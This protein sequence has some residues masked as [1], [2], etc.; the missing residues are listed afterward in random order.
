MSKNI[1]YNGNSFVKKAG[2]EHSFTKDQLEEY[3]RCSEDIVYFVKNYCKII[4]LDHGLQYF[5]PF[6]YQEKM[7]KVFSQERF[8][9]NL[10]PRQMGKSTV[11]A[12]YL[13]H[14]AIFTPDKSVG[15]LANKA[16]TSREILS[17]IQRMYE[18]LPLWLQP[19]V[20]EW[21]KG[22]MV[23]GNGSWLMAAATSSDSIRGFSFNVIY[24]D[25]FAHVDQQVEFWES[26]YPV[27]SSGNTSKVLITST[28]NGLDLFYKIYTEAEDGKNNFYPIKVNW[29]EHPA[30][31]DEWKRI[32]LS[33]IGLE[34]FKQEYEN[35]FLGSSGTLI[36][37]EKLA[38]LVIKE[39]I[40]EKD[41]IKQY[42]RPEEGHIYVCI[43]DVS[44]GKG[45]D[46]SAFQIMDITSMPY[47]QVCTFRDNTIT[48]ID[49]AEIIYRMAKIYNE[50][51]ILIEVNDI[52][53]QVSDVLHYDFEVETILYTES[54]GRA[55]KR[56]SGGFGSNV[57]KG[58][59]TTKSVKA[60]GCNMVKMLIEQDQ[61][62]V[63][64]FQ[65]IQELSTFSRK[66][67]SYE[68]EPGCYDDMVMCLVLFGWLS[69]QGFFRDL[70][71]INTLAKLK[72][73][74]EEDLYDEMLPIGFN[75]E[76]IDNISSDEMP[77]IPNWF[78]Y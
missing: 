71:D 69:D 12:A 10:L 50:A 39:P 57:D 73:R 19:G 61:L 25:E 15:I 72:Q 64:D 65:T 29:W 21:N 75:N 11:V 13:L 76:D 34:Q 54:A 26:T 5:D 78:N 35:A 44:R 77:Q 2:V 53:E 40:V 62:I 66:G 4:T 67:V 58:I 23:L 24:L 31:D 49:Y 60:I 51:Y 20:K 1:G 43:V 27:V 37:G 16:A 52:G 63:S 59:R 30:R 8:V 45:L 68:A 6:P 48:P 38:Q 70:T 7:L 28:P 46:Y 74:H 22:S 47:R 36:D 18:N 17:R 55:G 9:I 3:V 42:V 41:K 14:Y 32:T 33:N 56:I